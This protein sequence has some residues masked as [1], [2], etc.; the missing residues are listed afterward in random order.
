MPVLAQTAASSG[1]VVG[2]VLDKTGAAVAS[3]DVSVRSNEPGAEDH[4]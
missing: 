4:Q 1:Q 2:Q 3:T